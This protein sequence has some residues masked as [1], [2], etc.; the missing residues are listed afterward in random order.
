MDNNSDSTIRPDG[1]GGGTIRP[2]ANGAGNNNGATVRP[3]NGDGSN[4][5]TVRPSNE[6][7]NNG[8]TVRPSNGG[9]NNGSTVRPSTGGG[10]NGST[11]RPSTGGGNNGS[12]VR[13][14]NGGGNNGSTIRPSSGGGDGSKTMRNDDGQPKA[15]NQGVAAVAGAGVGVGKADKKDVADVTRTHE[16]FYKLGGITYKVKSVISASTGEAMVLLVENGGNTYVLKLYYEGIHPNHDI[17]AKV[18]SVRKMGLLVETVAHGVWSRAD[19]QQKATDADR[20]VRRDYE[21]MLYYPHGT[22]DQLNLRGDEKKMSEYFVQ[23]AAGINLCHV[24]GFLHRDIKPSN[25][26]FGD[27]ENKRV[28]LGDFGIAVQLDSNGVATTNQAR[29]KVY[30]APESYISTEGTVDITPKSDFYSLGMTLLCLWMGEQQFAQQVSKNERELAS[31]KT[32][33]KLPYPTDMSDHLLSLVKALTDPDPK[34]RP[35][36]TKIQEWAKGGDPFLAFLG[37]ESSQQKGFS[38]LFNGA[39]KLTAHSPKEL[40]KFMLD[41]PDLGISYLYHKNVKKWMEEF[42]RPELGQK[43]E[44]VVE[45][46][47]PK[48]Q[49]AGLYAACLYLDPGMTYTDIKGNSCSTAKDIAKSL[50][51]NFDKYKNN[52]NHVNDNLYV[53]LRV[54]GQKQLVDKTVADFSNSNISN[55]EALRRLIYQLDPI[56]PYILFT[57][58]GAA[59]L[60]GTPDEI[61]LQASDNNFTQESLKSVSDESFFIWL[62]KRDMDALGKVKRQ[63]SELP[64]NTSIRFVTVLYNLNPKVSYFFTLDESDSSYIFTHKQIAE[65]IN[66][67]MDTYTHTPKD[68]DAWDWADRFLSDVNNIDNTLLYAYFKSKDGR[69][70]QWITWLRECCNVKSQ[71]NQKKA[72]PYNWR[73]ATYKAIKGMGVEPFYHFPSCDISITS[74]DE[75]RDIPENE[76]RNEMENGMLKDWLAVFYQEDPAK[77]FSK[78]YSFEQETAKFTDK[79]GELNPD[80]T[81]YQ[82]FH[83]AQS[84][85]MSTSKKLKNMRGQMFALRTIVAVCCF[86]PILGLII[87]LLINGLPWTENPLPSWSPTAITAM[88][89]VFGLIA[90]FIG[91]FLDYGCIGGLIAAAIVGFL[92]SA[93]VYYILYFALKLLMPVA[94]YVIIGLLLLL[95]FFIYWSC[96]RKPSLKIGQHKNLF[97]PDLEHTVLEPLDYAYNRPNSD[98]DS[99]IYDDSVDY[100]NVLKDGRKSLFIRAVPIS[101]VT[102]LLLFVFI[103]YTYGGGFQFAQKKTNELEQLTGDWTGTFDNRDATVTITEIDKDG[104][105]KG[106]VSVRYKNQLHEQISGTVDLKTGKVVFDDMVTNGNLDGIY[107]GLL[108]KGEETMTIAGTYTNKKTGKKVEYTF[109]KANPE[110]QEAIES[111]ATDAADGQQ[112]P[113]TKQ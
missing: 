68:S 3:S 95:A 96:Y 104:A 72:A 89:L 106:V 16:P 17:L 108:D 90:M 12:T 15:V 36:F 57:E 44:Y 58:N 20:A 64:A 65:T 79:V 105:L 40:A 21:L 9:G 61:I 60:C 94:P 47:Y 59:V 80:D 33:G 98:F 34:K 14:S 102:A 84:Q 54:D 35:D 38:V 7:D 78:K 39:K 49:K 19:N 82:N 109:S 73:I 113:V 99:S 75:L 111:E 91:D 31:D 110:A 107:R 24:K 93:A 74:P 71:D 69:Y 22:M 85:V 77:N 43:M 112:E 4:G 29:T 88:T 18:E 45:T 25:F 23:M 92:I 76:I 28:L 87:M 63:L 2:D 83:D 6:G 32:L 56:Q 52:L 27:K 66:S 46:G 30:A 8:A 42:G 100:L 13:P 67:A 62:G 101:I 37:K 53:F 55:E 11:V 81:D 86:V 26:M 48:D 70:D 103:K 1:N 5:A 50:I 41:D 51:Q 97:Q 10:N